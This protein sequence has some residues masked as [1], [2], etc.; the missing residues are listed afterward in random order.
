MLG[1]T[2]A[3][4]LRCL[5]L[6]PCIAAAA[7]PA[8]AT[9]P[10][11]W[12]RGAFV[13]FEPGTVALDAWQ[14]QALGNNLAWLRGP[15]DCNDDLL[16]LTIR[17]SSTEGSPNQRRKLGQARAAYLRELVKAFGVTTSKVELDVRFAGEF[18]YQ[19]VA[20]VYVFGSYGCYR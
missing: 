8:L 3:I 6:L 13:V 7:G 17:T 20:D 9:T 1:R 2:V 10:P 14:R 12:Q 18:P 15:T 19:P 4:R 16:A 11:R 5:L